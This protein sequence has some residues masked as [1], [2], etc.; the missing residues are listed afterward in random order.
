[1]SSVG[2]VRCEGCVSSTDRSPP[3]ELAIE[4]VGPDTLGEFV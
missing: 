2:A 4:C 1:M 3:P